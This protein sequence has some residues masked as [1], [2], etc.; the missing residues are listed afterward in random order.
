MSI[1]IGLTMSKSKSVA[2]YEQGPGC[3]TCKNP[4][5]VKAFFCFCFCFFNNFDAGII[6]NQFC[7]C[8]SFILNW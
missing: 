2:Y 7:P 6:V 5:P 1:I 4:A 8:R 3:C